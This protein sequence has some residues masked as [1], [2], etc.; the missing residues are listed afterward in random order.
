MQFYP[1]DWLHDTALRR[2]S[3]V[4]RALWMDMLCLMHAG[5]PYGHLAT[6][7]EAFTPAE[8]AR[9][10][11][12][13]AAEVSRGLAALERAAVFSRTPDGTIFSRRMIRDDAER[14]RW[15]QS[16]ADNYRQIPADFPAD[17]RPDSRLDYREIPESFHKN[18]RRSSSSSSSSLHPPYKKRREGGARATALPD[19]WQPNDGHAKLAAELRLSLDGEVAQFGDYWRA[20]GKPMRDWD[21]CF[22]TWLR[23]ASRFG[24]APAPPVTPEQRQQSEQARDEQAWQKRVQLLQRADRDPTGHLRKMATGGLSVEQLDRLYRDAER[25]RPDLALTGAGRRA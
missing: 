8:L 22:R 13:T 5:E 16:K 18:S 1:G 24:G 25:E 7:G 15:R 11:G 10:T 3:P 4:A 17:S 23:N 12:M 2:V 14:T 6:G 19:G 21:A 20:K 9:A